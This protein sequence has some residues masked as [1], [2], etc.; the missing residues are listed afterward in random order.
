MDS[1]NE[2]LQRNID[3]IEDVVVKL[4]K[5]ERMKEKLKN[6]GPNGDVLK[7]ENGKFLRLA[8]E[9]KAD[10]LD[11][12]TLHKIKCDKHAIDSTFDQ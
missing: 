4:I 10:K 12:E 1:N 3:A 2:A 11:I 5:Q 6:E 8:L 9:M 7:G